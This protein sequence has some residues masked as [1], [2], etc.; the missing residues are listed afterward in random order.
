MTARLSHFLFC[1]GVLRSVALGVVLA[2]TAATRADV[3]VLSNR[4]SAAVPFRFVPQNGAAQQITL[5]V[6]TTMPLFLDGKANVFFASQGAPKRYTLDANCA[7]YFAR[8]ADGRVDLQKIGLGETGVAAEGRKLPGKATHMPQV[9]IPVKILVD[10]EERALPA[11]WEQRL[12]RRVESA[13]AIIER[14]GGVGFRVVAVGTWRTDN[15]INDFYDSLSEFES[16]VDPAPAKLAIGFTSQWQM[17]RGRVH[18]AGTRG[19]LHAHVLVR[20][21]SPEISEPERLEFLVHELGHYLGA[22]HSPEPDS[23]MRPVLGDKRAGRSDFRIQFDPVT[24]LT[25]S[26]VCEEIRRSNVTNVLQLSFVT[27]VRLEQIYKSL[28]ASLP[29]EDIAGMHYAMLMKT[30]ESPLV[31]ATKRVVKQIS[32]AASENRLLPTV[33]IQGS[34]LAVRREG[35]ALTNYYVREAA[36]VAKSLS[37]EEAPQAFLLGTAI[38]L[39]DSNALASIPSL[40]KLVAAIETPSERAIRVAMLG[41]PTVRNRLDASVHFFAA[42]F[43]TSVSN[44]D[45]TESALLDLSLQQARRPAGMSFKVIA[46]DRAGSR[47]GR[48]VVERRFSLAMLAAGFDV[49]SFVPELD[50][51]PDGVTAK[52]FATQ[53]GD[54]DDPRFV[55]KLREL[56]ERTLLL[57]GYRQTVLGSG[58]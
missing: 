56:D 29:R 40:A 30:S 12:R 14:H 24:T 10:E 9:T 58:R 34:K 27:R 13:S 31:A 1:A 37:D 57:P 32:Q 39:D 49:A 28:A 36:R 8:T 19:P 6:D 3:I 26:M 35:D 7:Y 11:V 16:K 52:D 46:A 55:K 20:E 54:K 45:A 51:L 21:G 47:F 2:L 48:S 33:A 18:M 23:V 41:K 22:A 4:T 43:L 53:F 50:S 15:S 38:G 44:A 5:A 42:A 17:S 25:M